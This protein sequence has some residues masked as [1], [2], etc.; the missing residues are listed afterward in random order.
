MCETQPPERWAQLTKTLGCPCYTLVG[1]WEREVTA[2]PCGRALVGSVGAC[3]ILLVIPLFACERKPPT[4]TPV[5][6]PLPLTVTPPMAASA[7]LGS[8]SRA[9]LH[10]DV[11][12]SDLV[13]MVVTKGVYPDGRP[14]GT[15]VRA[16]GVTWSPDGTQFAY[17]T[18]GGLSLNIVDPQG[19]ERTVFNAGDEF[20]PIYA[21][22]VWSPDGR[23]IA[24]IEVGWCEV[25]ER[26]SALVII[27]VARGKI[28]SR[29]GP[30]DFWQ[31][32]GTEEGPTYF[33]MPEKIR[34]SPDGGK[35]L[36]S[37]DKATVLDIVTGN[38]ETISDKR[39]IADWAPGSDAIY[40]FEIKDR[41]KTGG[42][43]LE[44]FYVKRLGS[45]G[46]TRLVDEDRLAGLSMTGARGPIP[47]II[48]LSPRGSK[49]AVTAGSSEESISRVHVYDLTE[50]ATIALDDPSK[51]FQASGV[52]MALDW[53]PGEDSLAALIVDETG[54]ATLRV[55]D[56]TTGVWRTLA[57]P[58]LDVERIDLI[59]KV[60]SWT[61]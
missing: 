5:S 21:W 48:V 61:R 30:Y 20:Q 34:W 37:W 59:P 33:T 44:S 39:V 28:S 23:K 32:G 1:S 22:P 60:L 53:A 55:V 8:P 40:Y 49:L 11:E 15:V 50:A 47:G 14:L 46:P 31:A 2:Y 27:D 24:V 18:P 7:D 29:L 6:S 43:A 19:E 35:I 25:G 13:N 56:L 16:V 9:I 36:V 42:K 41:T 57:T 3:L 58:V 12:V 52:I 4:S 10:M 38:I 45:G 51:S 26:I 17:V 54:V